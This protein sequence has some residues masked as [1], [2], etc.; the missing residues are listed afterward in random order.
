LIVGSDEFKL[1]RPMGKQANFLKVYLGGVK[2]LM[3]EIGIERDVAE[4]LD[5]GFY[6]AF[7]RVKY[8]QDWVV[9][10]AEL[11]GFVENLYGRRYYMQDERFFYKLCNYLIQGTCADMIKQF[12]IEI[13]EYIKKNKLKTVMVLPV[14]DELILS[15]PEDEEWIINDIKGIMEGVTHIIKTIPMVADV[16]FSDTNWGEKKGWVR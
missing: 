16:E 5:S 7:P 13:S 11:Y 8:Y 15:V 4:R 12:E 1:K 9:K 3:E 14:H 6:Q 10:Q 2:A